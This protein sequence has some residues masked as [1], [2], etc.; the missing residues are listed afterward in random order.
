MEKILEKFRIYPHLI[1]NMN[2]KIGVLKMFYGSCDNVLMG[3]FFQPEDFGKKPEIERWI[4]YHKF[5]TILMLVLD[6][7]VSSVNW[8]LENISS[9]LFL[10][11]Y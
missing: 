5:H 4:C 6:Q 9:I 2:E 7:S 8:I 11:L 3:N 10:S 1:D